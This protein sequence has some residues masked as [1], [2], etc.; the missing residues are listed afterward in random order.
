[1]IALSSGGSATSTLKISKTEITVG[2]YTTSVTATGKTTGTVRSLRIK[3][4]ILHKFADSFLLSQ[5]IIQSWKY[6][7]P[8]ISFQQQQ[9]SS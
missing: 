3:V 9:E 4:Q 7:H 8:R 1:M 2:S 5:K 6:H